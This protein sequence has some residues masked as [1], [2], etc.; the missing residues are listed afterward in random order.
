M[1]EIEYLVDLYVF[2]GGGSYEYGLFLRK[3]LFFWKIELFKNVLLV[4]VEGK[5][6][7][8]FFKEILYVRLR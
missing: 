6:F 2:F 5:D 1:F 3:F 4:S 8:F 7:Y